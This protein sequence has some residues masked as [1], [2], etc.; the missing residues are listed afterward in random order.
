[1]FYLSQIENQGKNILRAIYET[2]KLKKKLLSIE[3]F[4]D[5]KR[6]QINE[7]KFEKEAKSMLAREKIR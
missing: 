1:M 3:T 4:E 6:K 2:L 7:I 5:S